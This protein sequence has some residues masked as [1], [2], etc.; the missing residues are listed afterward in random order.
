MPA[1]RPKCTMSYRHSY[2]DIWI[3]PSI[4]AKLCISNAS[5]MRSR[6]HTTMR[7]VCHVG[8]S[9]TEWDTTMSY[10]DIMDRTEET[11]DVYKTDVNGSC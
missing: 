6:L 3:V 4:T 1:D 10:Y 7:D 5:R 8:I 9:W 11:F 2:A